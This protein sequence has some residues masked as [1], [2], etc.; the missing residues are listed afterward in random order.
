MKVLFLGCGYSSLASAR[1]LRARHPDAVLLGTSRSPE[2]AAALA[3]QGIE[4]L[5]FDDLATDPGLAARHADVTHIVHSIPPDAAGDPVLV[6]LAPFL[7]AAGSLKWIGYYSTIGVY[8]G[9]NGEWVDEQTPPRPRNARTERRV[10]AEAAWRDFGADRQI[11]VAVLRLAGIYGPG[12]SAFDKLADGSAHRI[13]KSGQVFNRIHVADIATITA[14]AAE[15]ELDGVYNIADDEPAPP[16]DVITFAAGLMGVQPPPETPF[17]EA[18][19]TPMQRSF[20]A[21]SRRVSNR[22]IKQAL[23]LAL[24]Y[25]DYRGGLAAIRQPG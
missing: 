11:P 7:A 9:E 6:G 17:D 13:V 10:L 15:R 12:R 2:G 8:G 1:V 24:H 21:E 22:A 20:Y 25:P 23:G 18:V 14:L 5:V 3:A 4:G 19:L 16:Q